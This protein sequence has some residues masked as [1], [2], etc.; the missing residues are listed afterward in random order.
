MLMTEKITQ[1]KAQRAQPFG[2]KKGLLDF[3]F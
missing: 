1:D 3:V 2:K